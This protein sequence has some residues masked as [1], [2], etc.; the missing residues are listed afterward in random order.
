MAISRRGTFRLICSTA[1]VLGVGAPFFSMKSSRAS[2]GDEP[3]TGKFEV[4][5]DKGGDFRWRLLS[6]NGQVV[7][8]SG[9]GYKEKR[10]CLNGIES[11]KRIAADSK[12][13]DA[14]E[15]PSGGN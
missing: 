7:A 1:L 13:E 8:T 5:Q 14:K 4:Y 6:S 12:V 3:R 15:P 9:Q 10:D 2:A 11:V